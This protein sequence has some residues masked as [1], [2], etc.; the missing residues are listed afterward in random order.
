MSRYFGIYRGTVVNNVDPMQMG[1][2]M[3]IVPD[4]GGVTPSTWAMPC[5]PMA[6]KQMGAFF[7]PQIGAGVW[8]QFEGGDPD[9]P[10]WTGGWWG[11]AA[12]VPALALAGP[13]GDPNIVLQTTLQ[14]A[15]VVS[16]LPARPAGSC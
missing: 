6:G 12:E 3:V 9:Y 7:V 16:D 5:V 2:I 1:R 15:V 4:V 10:V 11:N 14:N 13:P 8:M